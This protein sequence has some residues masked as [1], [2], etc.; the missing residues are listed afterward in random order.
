LSDTSD[1]PALQLRRSLAIF[2]IHASWFVFSLRNVPEEQSREAGL[3]VA[4]ELFSDRYFLD[5]RHLQVQR[6]KLHLRH[7]LP[8]T[9]G[10]ADEAELRVQLL[11]S[12]GEVP[13]AD[14]HRRAAERRRPVDARFHERA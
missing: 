5:R 6:E 9:L 1:P 7:R 4:F 14:H 2:A 12:D 3:E 8:V 11:S 13:D 10:Q